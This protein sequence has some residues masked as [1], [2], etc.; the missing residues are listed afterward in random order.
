MSIYPQTKTWGSQQSAGSIW[1][2]ICFFLVISDFRKPLT[3]ALLDTGI[4][5]WNISAEICQLVVHPLFQLLPIIPPCFDISCVVLLKPG[6]VGQGGNGWEFPGEVKV[7]LSGHVD[8]W[9]WFHPKERCELQF[10]PVPSSSRIPPR[11]KIPLLN[12][13]CGGCAF[14]LDLWNRWL[15]G[16]WGFIQF[17]AFMVP[18]WRSK[19]KTK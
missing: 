12:A 10:N 2:R 9:N 14:S 17:F 16:G 1:D 19:L 15:Q 11:G 4:S 7:G 3:A 5:Q 13:G 8:P 6:H 18:L